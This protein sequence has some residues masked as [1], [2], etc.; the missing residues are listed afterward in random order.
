MGSNFAG[1]K[2]RMEQLHRRLAEGRFR[3]AVLG[4]FKRGKSSL[5]NALWGEPLLPTG[6]LPLTSIPTV[7]RHG[8]ERRIRVTLS[9]GRCE[10]RRGSLADLAPL[11]MRYVTER[12]NPANRLGVTEVE[13]Q[14]P[15]PLLA[16][17]MEIID[18]PG[19]GSTVLHNTR[20]AREILPVCDGALFVLSPDPPI[21]EVEVQF[22][23]SVKDA[24]AR[25]ILVLTK[26]DLLSQPER[27]EILAFL[28][29]VLHQE[30]G[31][32]SREQVFLISAQQGLEARASGDQALWSNSGVGD[33]ESYLIDFLLTD[34]HVALQEAIRTK[35]AR[36][37][38]EALFAVDFQ[39]KVIE[40]PREDLERRSE[41]FDAHLEKMEREG[42]Y[43]R[44]RL[45]GDRQRLLAELDHLAEALVE[46][47]TKALSACIDRVR[48]GTGPDTAS[49]ELRRRIYASLSEEVDHVFGHA[50]KD[51]LATVANQLQTVQDTHCRDMENLIDRVRRTAADLFEVPCLEGVA[52]DRLEAIREPQVFRQRWVTSFTEE[53]ASWLDLLLPPRLRAKRREQRLH[54]TI[55]YLV[56]RN[57]EELR[58]VTR[59]N[60]EE[61]FR[62]FQARME[63][64]L[65]ATI[66]GIRTAIRTALDRQ[67]QREAS[68]IPQLEKLEGFRQQLEHLLA[69]LAP[70]AGPASYGSPV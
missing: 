16:K 66:S 32:C 51:L 68:S 55:K 63:V 3:L 35:A 31:F 65:V 59:Q 36:L 10:D 60:L 21:T 33:L 15:A 2:G 4:Q 52:L 30:V 47:A 14:H 50:A 70:Q 1:I 11:L 28:Q 44:D 69:E 49:K 6:V 45:A 58:W 25:V 18:T 56:A 48:E 19:I 29:H 20:T 67:A 43:F 9:D 26:A 39:R 53:A 23:K 46:P 64:Q 17:G 8:P 13:V 7:L 54:E 40:L 37:T 5:L 57:V 24:A 61:M 42:V 12:Q 41:R 34:K 22:L 27:R 62:M 38:G